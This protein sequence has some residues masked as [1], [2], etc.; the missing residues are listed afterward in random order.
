VTAPPSTVAV[1]WAGVVTAE[2]VRLSPSTSASL[3]SSCTTIDASSAVVPL[4]SATV[5][6]SFNDDTV[7]ATAAVACA[8]LPSV[9]V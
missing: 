4:S 6:W 2:I 1:P 5:G 9:T 3:L 8:P 7:T